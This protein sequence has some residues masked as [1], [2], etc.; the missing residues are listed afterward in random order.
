[1][2]LHTPSGLVQL[3][4]GL[5]VTTLPSKFKNIRVLLM[6]FVTLISTAG[7]ALIY[8]VDP[9][10]K[11]IRL[12]GIYMCVTYGAAFP[13]TLSF[14]SSNVGGFTKKS[15]ASAML[16]VGYCM[17]ILIGLNFYLLSEAPNYPV[18]LNLNKGPRGSMN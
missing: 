8:A 6:L 14:I 13:L 5:L 2:L 3:A 10:H 7:M 15:T 16:F 1:M 11:F 17:G 4:F 18:H 12:A 9:V